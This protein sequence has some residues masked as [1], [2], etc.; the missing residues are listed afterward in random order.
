VGL[1]PALALNWNQ[2]P[3]IVAEANRIYVF[4]RLP[5]HLSL[6]T[7]SPNEVAVRL[8]WHG[9][10]VICLWGLTRANRRQDAY[11]KEPLR[12]VTWYA[13]GAVVLAAIGFV[14]EIGFWY[15]PQIAA[16]LLRYYWFRLT[17]VAVPL[18]VAMQAVTLIAS[19]FAERRPWAVWALAGAI[20][21]ALWHVGTATA[22]RVINP[23]PPADAAMRDPAAWADACEW[24]AAN[25]P[26]EAVFLTPRLAN[27]FKWRAGRAEVA[28]HKDIPQNARSMVAWFDRL[29]DIFYYQLGDDAEPFNSVGELG[30]ERAVALAK[31]YGASYIVSDQDHPLALKSIYPNRKYPNDKYV[32]YA[33]ED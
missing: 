16:A 15:Q 11:A 31:K 9:L 10:L 6:L 33:L 17:D 27:T 4:E 1:V 30:T 21:I 5:H 12:I 32:V 22:E 24:I 14:I 28:T 13:W 18:A 26:Q 20:A 7:L 2:P 25:T 19:G 29:Q 8:F 3:E 23:F